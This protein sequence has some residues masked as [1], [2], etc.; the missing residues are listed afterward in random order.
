MNLASI[1]LR[2]LLY[3]RF[4]YPQYQDSDLVIIQ[5]LDPESYLLS[6]LT[7]HDDQSLVYPDHSLGSVDDFVTTSSLHQLF[8]Q[9]TT[10]S[11]LRANISL[12][13]LN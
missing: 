3:S 11:R 1:N 6:P 13:T 8:V 12:L 9:T 4:I 10:S 5:T 7:L 2:P